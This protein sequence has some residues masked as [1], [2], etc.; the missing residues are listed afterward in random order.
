MDRGERS[1]AI[2][3]GLIVRI[4]YLILAHD[5]P[6]HLRRLVQRLAA[7]GAAFYVH[8]DAKAD[9]GAFACLGSA[10]RFCARRVNCAWGDI[11]LVKATLKLMKCAASEPRGF[12]RF[13]LLSGACYPLQTPDYIEEFLTRHRGTEFIEAFALPTVTYNK[14]LERITRFWIRKGK[15]LA[16]LRWPLQHF[17]N[18]LLP[19]RNYQKV[20]TGGEPVT[21][22]QWWC[23]TGEA[24]RHV[25]DVT[26]RQPAL[27]RF[28]KFVDCPDEFYFQVILWNS[29]FRA[30]I[31]H[32]LTFTHWSPGKT[33]PELLDASYLPQFEGPVIRDSEFNNCPGEKREVLFARKFS[34]ASAPVLDAIDA[35]AARRQ[36][37]QSAEQDLTKYKVNNGQD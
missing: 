4:A 11:S 8:L 6:A 2:G 34:E 37:R 31:S 29:R 35:L 25:L 20:L 19:L 33:G 5:N 21:G 15:P 36:R 32:S 28:C 30:S 7:P 13:V 17:L 24:V 1:G 27:Y 16:R 23:L 9:L 26:A 10:V 22:S 3:Q 18:K 12:D 14:P